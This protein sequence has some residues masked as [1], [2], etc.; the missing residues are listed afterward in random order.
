[1][2]GFD[3]R[4]HRAFSARMAET[5]AEAQTAL[6]EGTASDFADYRHRVGRLAGMRE[7]LDTAR[8]VE[9]MLMGPDEENA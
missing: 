1:M 8:E 9:R 4:F 6:V 2:Q 7:A 5:I 3:I